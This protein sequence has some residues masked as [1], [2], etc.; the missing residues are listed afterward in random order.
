VRSFIICTHPQI[1]LGRSQI[2]ENEV[3]R[4]FG[5][6]GR[7]MCTRFRWE[8]QKED[9]LEDQSIDGRMGLECILGRLAWGVYSG[10]IWLRI[11]TSGRL[12]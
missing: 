5:M 7:G 2:K 3:G 4:P 6:H 8:S 9:H 12:L 10:S 1:L 11:G